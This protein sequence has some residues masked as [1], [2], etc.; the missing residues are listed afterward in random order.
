MPNNNHRA[1]SEPDKRDIAR[2]KAKEAKRESQQSYRDKESTSLDLLAEKL[3]GH[4]TRRYD[5]L[6]G[7]RDYIEM[8]ENKIT[9][10]ENELANMKRGFATPEQNY[11]N[12]GAGGANTASG[13][14]IDGWATPGQY[15]TYSKRY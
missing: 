8:L 10:M 7:A 3:P 4:P 9:A 1:T 12:Y 13:M 2:D 14:S 6:I 11:G 15:S 5:V